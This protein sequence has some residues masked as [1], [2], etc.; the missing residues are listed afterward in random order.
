MMAVCIGPNGHP[1][2]GVLDITEY[3]PEHQGDILGHTGW[4][5]GQ[6]PSNKEEWSVWQCSRQ[7]LTLAEELL[8]LWCVCVCVI[9]CVVCDVEGWSFLQLLGPTPVSEHRVKLNSRTLE[10]PG[11]IFW[12]S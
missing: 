7:K 4:S 1:C 11:A 10:A 8:K 3:V 6:R 9:V 2:S 12:N 5:S